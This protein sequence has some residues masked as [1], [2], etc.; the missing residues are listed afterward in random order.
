MLVR[1]VLLQL[2]DSVGGA[3]AA[4]GGGGGGGG[5]VVLFEKGDKMR[6]GE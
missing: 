4:R 3:A 6:E 1:V 2:E 5:V